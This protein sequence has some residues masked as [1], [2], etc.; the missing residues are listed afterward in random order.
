MEIFLTHVA[1]K[2]R[3]IL[4]VGMAEIKTMLKQLSFSSFIPKDTK[5]RNTNSLSQ[6]QMK[7]INIY[8]SFPIYQLDDLTNLCW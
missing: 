8:F 5:N 6:I 1:L 4:Q 3:W 7:E 2:R